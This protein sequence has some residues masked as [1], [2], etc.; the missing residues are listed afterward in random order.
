MTIRDIA[1]LS[2]VSVSTVSRVLNNH[3]DVSEAVRSRVLAVVQESHYVPNN[4]AR[5]LVRP[6]SD[7][8]GLVVRGIGNPFYSPVIHAIEEAVE[9]AGYTLVLHQIH[10]GED[11]LMA[12]ASLARSKKLRGLVLL[13]GCHDYQPE[14]IAALDVPFV[15]CTYTNSFGTLAQDAY[16]SVSIDDEMEAYRAVRELTAR[17]HRN[18]A[19]LLDST[20]DHSISQLRYKG[21]CRALEEVGIPLNPR[22]VEETGTFELSAAYE[23]TRRLLNRCGEMTAIF[24]IADSM[25]MAAMKAVHDSGRRVP[26]E[27]SVIAIDGIEMSTYMV[28]TLTTLIQPKEQMG[29][30]A[31]RILLDMVEGR[32]GNRRVLLHTTLRNGESVC[33]PRMT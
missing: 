26:E 10:S 30:E 13:G 29:S 7:N 12:G 5:D 24:A 27:C 32:A 23:G 3:P 14:T 16:S 9:Q 18:I 17:G 1:Q 28:P 31:V 11:E 8:I 22:M 6:Q 19:V 2:G 33:A 15:C 20:C 21:Y 25:A 4:S